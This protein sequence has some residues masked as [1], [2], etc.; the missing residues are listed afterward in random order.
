MPPRNPPG[1]RSRLATAFTMANSENK[2][3]DLFKKFKAEKSGWTN[4]FPA[5]LGKADGTIL[6]ETNGIVYVRHSVNGRVYQAYNNG[7]PLDK[8]GLHIQVGRMTDETVLRIKSIDRTHSETVNNGEVLQSLLDELFISRERFLP[9]L[10]LPT[11]GGG[12]VVQVYGDVIIKSDGSFGWIDNQT[13]DLSSHV[14]T[15]GALFV[16]IES[17]DDGVLYVTDGTP[18]ASKELLTP[19]DIPSITSGRKP[20]C[21]VRLYDGQTQLY[22]D[23]NSVS[24]FVDARSLTSG[25]GGGGGGAVDSVNGYTGVVVLDPDDLDDSATTNKFT[26]AGDISKLAGI[27][28]TAD[29]TDISNVGSSLNG[30]SADTPLDSDTFHFWDAVDTVMKKITWANIKA[31][32]K[33]YF[34]T[35]YA[36]ITG[37]NYYLTDANEFYRGNTLVISAFVATINGTPSGSTL[38][39]NAPSAGNEND[40]EQFNGSGVATS[41]NLAKVV[42]FNTTRGNDALV[43]SVNLATNVITLTAAVPSGWAN[44][45]T[46]KTLRPSGAFQLRSLELADTSVVPSGATHVFLY[47]QIND[48]AAGGQVWLSTDKNSP[49][50]SEIVPI[51]STSAASVAFNAPFVVIPITNRR[52]THNYRGTSGLLLLRIAGY[53]L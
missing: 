47:V 48:S 16:L 19:A 37:Q 7:A 23:K 43:S 40:L 9:F 53:V 33:T 6:T 20:S 51:G 28:S 3:R 36:P 46:I 2:L 41:S 18:V 27:E 4:L 22:R 24:D 32:L 1:C 49:S 42:L 30:A 34:D 15:A 29:V 10:I 13:L 21:A 25:G 5:I 14:P 45:D 50:T 39:Y 26:T 11:D 31:T 52:I 17:D 38:T 44:G 35:L 12:F 8:P